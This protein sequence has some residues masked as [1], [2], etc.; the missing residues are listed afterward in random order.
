[1]KAHKIHAPPCRLMSDAS[2][3]TVMSQQV[4]SREERSSLV[5][6]TPPEE[7]FACLGKLTWRSVF[8]I[9]TLSKQMC[10]TRCSALG[11]ALV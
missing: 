1:M 8:A 7:I 10:I 2:R 9:H 3:A 4:L 5:H 11:V 6:R